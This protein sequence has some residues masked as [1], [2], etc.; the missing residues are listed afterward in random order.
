MGDGCDF[1]K[2]WT[3][4]EAVAKR[5]GLSMAALLDSRSA[6]G[7]HGGS[8]HELI[9]DGRYAAAVALHSPAEIEISSIRWDTMFC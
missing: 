1:I 4:L 2:A 3:G 5:D 6:A 8:V 9:I 7:T